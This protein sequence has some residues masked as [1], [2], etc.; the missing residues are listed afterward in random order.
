MIYSHIVKPIFFKMDPEEVH[1]R[2][3]DW[4][5]HPWIASL[6]NFPA[7]FSQSKCEVN[8]WGIQF[9]NPMGLAAGF[10]KN[11]LALPVWDK[12][13]FG[14]VEIGTVT[15]HPQEGNPKPR[16]FRIPE[17]EALINRMGFPNEGADV[18]RNRL[19]FYKS[20]GQWPR[21]PVGINIGKSK[22]TDLEKAPE[23][24]LGSFQRLS[25]FADYVAI[26]VSSP[27]TP[28]LR[29]LQTKESL[30][31]II[32]PIQEKN[33]RR[34]PLLVKI[35]PDLSEEELDSVLEA[36]EVLKCQGMIATNTTLDKSSVALKEEGGLSGE[37][38]RDRSTRMIQSI[39][40]K[41][42]GSLPIIGVGGIQTAADAQEK[43][44]AGASLLQVYTGFIYQGPQ[45]VRSIV[46][47]LSV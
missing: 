24:Y 7:I 23:D 26:N 33:T 41:T 6:L 31:K 3:M 30:I 13:G 39:F 44:K 19:E 20:S 36:V 22:I 9:P 43:L 34:I 38:V 21:I 12:F 25:P 35:A 40:R 17:N 11:A 27:N 32:E 16:I 10:D 37:P 5:R 4:I 47:S 18:I 28:G 29:S 1:H 14:H 45:M 15:L 8:Q 46:K 2:V 42:K